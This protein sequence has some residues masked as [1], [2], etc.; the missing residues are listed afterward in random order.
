MAYVHTATDILG[1]DETVLVKAKFYESTGILMIKLGE[2]M[3]N[4]YQDCRLWGSN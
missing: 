1:N 2:T 4:L 3:K